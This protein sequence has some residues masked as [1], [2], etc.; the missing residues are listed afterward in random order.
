MKSYFVIRTHSQVL[1]YKAHH[2]TED[3]LFCLTD[4]QLA[5]FVQQAL[6]CARVLGGNDRSVLVEC[7]LPKDRL[8]DESGLRRSGLDVVVVE[9]FN[10]REPVGDLAESLKTRENMLHEQRLRGIDNLKQQFNAMS[11]PRG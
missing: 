4:D 6:P 2:G 1:S 11:Q 10:E 8:L 5:A 3:F 7:D 9:R